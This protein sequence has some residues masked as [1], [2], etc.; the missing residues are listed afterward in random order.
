LRAP[1][2]KPITLCTFQTVRHG[3]RMRN[4]RIISTI[5]AV[6]LAAIAG[7]LVWKYVTNADSR[8]EKNKHLVTVLV[9]K[10]RIARGTVFD[11]V[12][13]DKGFKNVQL[14]ADSLPPDRILPRNDQA[15][16]AI[17]KGRVAATDIFAGTPVIGDQ[18]VQSSQL[19][20]TVAGAIPKGKEAITVSLDPT[21]AV[22]GFLTPGDKVNIIVNLTAT[23]VTKKGTAGG[24]QGVRT[25]A[26]LLAGV[27]VIAVGSTTIVPSSSSSAPS[28]SAPSSAPPPATGTATTTTQVQTQPM[29]LITL[30]V[31]PRQAE[32]IV[33]AT[34]I[35]TLYLSL[36]PPGFDP[37][38][39]TPPQQIVQAVNLFDAISAAG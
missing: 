24:D 10:D 21:H 23:D 30:E 32:Q 3:E 35:G 26:F 6:V 29:S 33:Q 13:A 14:P 39:F 38:R 36:N 1:P 11:Q 34:T 22:G 15:L 18:F 19:I 9:A 17:F 28:S 25:T 16:L 12:V 5:A 27:K 20:N 4:W 8:A 37:K 7:G 2:W 31:T